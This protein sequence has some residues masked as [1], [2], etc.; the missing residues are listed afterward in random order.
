MGVFKRL[1]LLVGLVGCSGG[2][3]AQVSSGPEPQ[4]GIVVPYEPSPDNVVDAM[5][6]LGKVGPQDFV[7]DLGSGDGRIVIAAAKKYGALALGVDLDPALVAR[8]RANAEAAGVADRVSF[9]QEDIFKTD[10]SQATVITMFL[11]PRVNLALRPKLLELAPGTRVVSHFH[12]MAEWRPDQQQHLMTTEHYGDTWIFLWYVPAKVEG[13]W[14]WMAM[15]GGVMQRHVLTLHQRFQEVEGILETESQ[16]PMKIR[17][18]KL[19]GAHLSFWVPIRD[20][21]RTA[22]WDF[23]G[24][25]GEGAITGTDSTSSAVERFEQPWRATHV[26]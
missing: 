3:P 8:S 23:V 20:S 7:I 2:V 25:V 19:L 6:T 14:Q 26:E 5:L 11:F 10:L 9:R 12:D 24:E 18:A 13:A 16:R 4:G 17:D 15:R 21:G 1:L 22:R